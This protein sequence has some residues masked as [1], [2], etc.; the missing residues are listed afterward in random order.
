MTLGSF[1]AGATAEG[2]A[3]VA[4]PVFTKVLSIKP[5]IARTF[6]L[7]IQSVGMSMASVVIIAKQIKVLPKVVFYVTLGG[8]LGQYFGTYHLIM[9]NPYP[10]IL[11]T[12]IAAAF[13]I[14]LFISR[15][16]L[17]WEPK[18]EMPLWSIWTICLFL[19][20]GVGGGIFAAQT[21]S[22]IDMLTYIFLILMFGINEKI[23]TP[24]T[25][26][27]MALNS[28][29]GTFFHAVVSKDV[30]IAFDYWL[31]AV[32]I[33]VIGAP[34]GA[35][36]CSYVT[37]D[38]IIYFL[39]TLIT[40]EVATTL[41]LVNFGNEEIVISMIAIGICFISFSG[42]ILFRGKTSVRN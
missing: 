1:V 6:G 9:A 23:S 42:M 10:R 38:F 24:T 34:M 28:I 21:G 13:G 26:V 20:I 36:C 19:V 18:S 37:R 2:G 11:F 40:L 17:K 39:L 27:I 3:A 14:A 8:I 30:G 4:F 25:V 12:F 41:W 29:V 31:V 32:P 5:G 15:F 7:M 35:T 22:G 33:V 16:H